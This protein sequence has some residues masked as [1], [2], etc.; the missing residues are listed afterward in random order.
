MTD[1]TQE[2]FEAYEDVRLS[3]VTNMWSRDVETLAGISDDTHLSIMSNY[4]DLCDR[5][6]EV[7][8]LKG[9]LDD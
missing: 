7:R 5:W 1:V 6:P 3:G 2:D 9:R 4:K 8:D